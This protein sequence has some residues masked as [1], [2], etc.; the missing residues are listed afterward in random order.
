MLKRAEKVLGME[1]F[2]RRTHFRF[3]TWVTSISFVLGLFRSISLTFENS[4]IH[5]RAYII[6]E[7]FSSARIKSISS[8]LFTSSGWAATSGK[9]ESKI[10][11]LLN[12][13]IEG[14]INSN[15]TRSLL[16]RTNANFSRFGVFRTSLKRIM[17]AVELRLRS[18]HAVYKQEKKCI[19]H[20]FSHLNTHTRSLFL[21]ARS[22]DES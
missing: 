9:I 19:W 7:C 10:Y 16:T 15:H 1:I 22:H 3:A 18:F 14:V 6:R 2:R 13:S 8:L 5:V 11:F 4:K 21:L 12:N 17:S 20:L